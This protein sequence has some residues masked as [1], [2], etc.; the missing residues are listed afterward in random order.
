L[1]CANSTAKVRPMPSL[2]IGADYYLSP[3]SKVSFGYHAQQMW[4]VDR[5]FD[6]DSGDF[7]DAKPRLI[8]GVFVGY[9]TTF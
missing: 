5:H 7:E 6:E 9:T 1:A 3:T 2:Q 8:H 4:N